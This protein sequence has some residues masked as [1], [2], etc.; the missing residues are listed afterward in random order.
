MLTLI[1]RIALT[2]LFAS[3]LGQQAVA[4]T[5]E[6]MSADEALSLE[7]QT[8]Y[9]RLRRFV[10]SYRIF[11]EPQFFDYTV[12]A[13]NMP[14]NFRHDIPVLRIVFPEST[15][16]DTGSAEVLPSAY[17]II[18]AMAKMLDGD[19]PDVNVFVAGHTDSRGG[20]DYN[21]N[22]SVARAKAVTAALVGSRTR[23]YTIWS[24]GFGES[25]PIYPNTDDQNMAYNRRVEFLLGARPEAVS[26]WL[27]Q[28]YDLV[29]QTSDPMAKLRCMLELKKVRH[30]YEAEQEGP[31]QPVALALPKQNRVASQG[32]RVAVTPTAPKRMTIQLNEKR[33]R[34]GSI[35]H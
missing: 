34:V 11:P 15:F 9:Q 19:V 2:W 13:A 8:R 17:P 27:Q 5:V 22:L 26:Y 10:E 24:I 14:A 20:E 30:V 6:Y 7:H 29:C 12:P 21:H 33:L 4:Q 32:A 23:S 18:A 3:L 25:L 31:R 28:Q 1:R 35:E 16:F